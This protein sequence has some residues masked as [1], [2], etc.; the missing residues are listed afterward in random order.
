MITALNENKHNVIAKNSEK[1]EKYYCSCCDE[2]VILKKGSIKVHHFSHKSHSDCLFQGKPESEEHK[3]YKTQIYETFKGQ[4]L[5]AVLED[6]SYKKHGIIPDITV[7]GYA[8]EIQLSSITRDEIQRRSRLMARARLKPLWVF[9]ESNRDKEL[10]MQK[11]VLDKW[12]M[13]LFYNE[14]NNRIVVVEREWCMVRKK[15]NIV[16]KKQLDVNAE[17]LVYAY[18]GVSGQLKGEDTPKK[19]ENKWVGKK[20]LANY[21]WFSYPRMGIVKYKTN[22]GKYAVDLETPY[23]TKYGKIKYTVYCQEYQLSEYTDGQE[24][25]APKIPD[26]TDKVYLVIEEGRL[27]S[28]KK[29]FLNKKTAL[30]L[31][32]KEEEKGKDVKIVEYVHK[33]IT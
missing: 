28:R 26:N 32:Y 13:C 9:G 31:M 8:V 29:L 3:R 23:E 24:V 14:E 21:H 19:K 11:Y 17:F 1:G 5:D 6:T 25:C 22:T 20:V 7:N 16:Q 10:A 2:E 12:K 27:P 33:N 30:D 15:F 4:G 18:K